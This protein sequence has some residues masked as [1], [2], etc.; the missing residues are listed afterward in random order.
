M[1][2]C[3]SGRWTV[4][5]GL[6][7]REYLVSESRKTSSGTQEGYTSSNE[8]RAGTTRFARIRA[9]D[10]CLKVIEDRMIPQNG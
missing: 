8:N 3:H 5:R 7:Q 1:K 2:T 9:E 4:T 10:V 6:F